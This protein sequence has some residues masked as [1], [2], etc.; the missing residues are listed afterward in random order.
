MSSLC[1]ILKE[2]EKIRYN[3]KCN[4]VR[5]ECV[6]LRRQKIT[7]FSNVCG[8]LWM[9]NSSLYF[10]FY[11]NKNKWAFYVLIEICMGWLF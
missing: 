4:Y 5:Q 3:F 9:L 7:L 2:K 6:R 11:E 1:S 8:T 10:M